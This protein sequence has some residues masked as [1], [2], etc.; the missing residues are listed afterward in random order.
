M[1]GVGGVDFCESVGAFGVFVGS[2]S[3]CVGEGFGGFAGVAEG[4]VGFFVGFVG[5]YP[6]FFVGAVVFGVGGRFGFFDDVLG[7]FFYGVGVDGEAVVWCGHG[8]VSFWGL[9]GVVVFIIAGWCWRWLLRRRRSVRGGVFLFL[10]LCAS[11]G[12]FVRER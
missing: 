10:F 11:W 8:G 12:V 6:E 3:G 1:C 5:G 7:G 9:G 4:P 2:S